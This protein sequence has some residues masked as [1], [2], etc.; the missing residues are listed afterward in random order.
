MKAK[1][2]L[3]FFVFFLL[4]LILNYFIGFEKAVIVCLSGIMTFI[5]YIG[6]NPTNSDKK[7]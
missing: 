5:S 7:E 1:F 4:N 2:Y 3:V 6:D